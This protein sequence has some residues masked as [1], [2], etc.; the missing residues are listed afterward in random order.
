[1]TFR[2][3]VTAEAERDL[4]EIQDWLLSQGAGETGLRWLAGLEDAITSLAE[5]PE[6]CGLAPEN[7]IVSSE[8]RHLLYG[9]KPNVYRIIF[10]IDQGTVYVVHVRHGR[11]QPVK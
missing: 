5:L 6:R 1:M 8:V 3:E 11:R 7:R 10:K 9:T 4:A 2:V